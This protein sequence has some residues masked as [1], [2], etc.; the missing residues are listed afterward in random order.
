MAPSA[1]RAARA[2]R[3]KRRS[4]TGSRMAPT[5]DSCRLRRASH[6]SSHSVKVPRAR[7]AARV[8]GRRA[9]TEGRSEGD[10]QKGEGVR[11]VDPVGHD[12]RKVAR[13]RRR[14]SRRLRKSLLLKLLQISGP[15]LA[16]SA[17]N[18]RTRRRDGGI[19]A[20]G[21]RGA[22]GRRHGLGARSAAGVCAGVGRGGG[23]VRRRPG[24]AGGRR[25]SERAR[26]SGRRPGGAAAVG[27]LAPARLGDGCLLPG[28]Q[29]RPCVDGR[30]RAD[31]R[32]PQ[33]GGG[34]G[35]CD[36]RG[37]EAV[38]LRRRGCEGDRDAPGGRRGRCAGGLGAGALAR[39]SGPD[40]VAGLPA[41]RDRPGARDDRPVGRGAGVGDRAGGCAGPGGTARR[42]RRRPAERDRLAAAGDAPLHPTDGGA[43]AA[44]A[45]SHRRAAG[46]RSRSWE[47]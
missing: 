2:E 20:M 13:A 25:T 33:D 10:P 40:A 41:I 39:G 34:P 5:E 44:T 35:R 23:R 9:T 24:S 21:Q 15:P 4:A 30:E 46:R 31:R 3:T 11:D 36:G 26:G 6:P 29:G 18:H 7:M 47:T 1:A 27:R 37:P 14:R 22:C 19:E 42:H 45:L 16:L 43:G 8:R 17:R 38:A 12:A 28:P 32:W